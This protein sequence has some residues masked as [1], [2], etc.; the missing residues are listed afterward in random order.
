MEIPLQN[1]LREDRV[2][3]PL[4]KFVTQLLQ[5]GTLLPLLTSGS[6]DFGLNF[7]ELTKNELSKCSRVDK[8][9]VGVELLCEMLQ[10]S[11]AVIKSYVFSKNGYAYYFI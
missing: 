5:S 4:M 7:I 10:G 8:I 11:L 1:N 9:V 6:D 3:I 2:S